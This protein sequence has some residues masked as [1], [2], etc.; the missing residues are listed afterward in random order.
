MSDTNGKAFLSDAE[1]EHA[2][3][4]IE[5]LGE[6]GAIRLLGIARHTFVRGIAGLGMREGTAFLY[7]ERLLSLEKK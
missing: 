6:A 1:R 7:R 4:L 2:R 3:R 5:E